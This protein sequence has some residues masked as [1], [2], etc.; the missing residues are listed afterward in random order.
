[1]E[2]TALVVQIHNLQRLHLFRQF[3]CSNICINVEDLTLLRFSKAAQDGESARA[4]RRFD[5]ALVDLGDLPDKPVLVAVEVVGGEDARCYR[6]CAAAEFLE[7]GDEL[8]VLFEE[9]SSCDFQ[10]FCV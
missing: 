6:T 1:M 7:C 3:T 5:R 4:D 10:C 8:E 9:D 2:K